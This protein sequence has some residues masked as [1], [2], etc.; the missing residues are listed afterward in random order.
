MASAPEVPPPLLLFCERGP[1]LPPEPQG[2]ATRH[3]EPPP[4]APNAIL[5]PGATVRIGRGRDCERC[6]PR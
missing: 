2:A 6:S 1:D 5:H 3:A 4:G